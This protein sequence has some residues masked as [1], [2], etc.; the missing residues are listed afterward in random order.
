MA[1]LSNNLP[2]IGVVKITDARL[3]YNGQPVIGVRVSAVPFFKNSLR[4][5][6]DVLADGAT[7]HND[8]PVIGV[9]VVS[10][11]DQAL[12]NNQEIMPVVVI[13]GSLV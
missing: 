4:R 10:D 2:V 6:I 1:E 9:S 5:G 8:Q 11:A 3:I 13:S 12:F 7:L